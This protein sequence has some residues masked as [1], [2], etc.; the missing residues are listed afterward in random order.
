MSFR[1]SVSSTTFVRSRAA[2]FQSVNCGCNNPISSSSLPRPLTLLLSFFAF[3]SAVEMSFSR[4]SYCP[5]I[6]FKERIWGRYEPPVE[7]KGEAQPTPSLRC[8]NFCL[9]NL[10]LQTKIQVSG[11]YCKLVG[12][13]VNGSQS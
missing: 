2:K 6:S 11:D 9:K 7:A 4:G 12:E 13:Q 3:P 5:K 10:Y 1:P 8:R